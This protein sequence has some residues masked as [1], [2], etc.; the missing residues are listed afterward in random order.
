MFNFAEIWEWRAEGTNPARRVKRNPEKPRERHLLPEEIAKLGRILDERLA[1]GLETPFIV[2]VFKL[3]LLT[4]CRHSEIQT[5]KWSYL[6]NGAI[7]L[8]ETKTGPRRIPL[9]SAAKAILARLPRITDNPFVIA[10]DVP[11]QYATDLQRPWRRIREAAGLND[12]RIHDLRHTYASNA[13]KNGES[14]PTVGKLLGQ[15]QMQTTMRYAHWEDETLCAAAE[16]VSDAINAALAAPVI[17]NPFEMKSVSVGRV[18]I[19]EPA[20]DTDANDDAPSN[21]R[22]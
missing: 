14:L 19:L 18:D 20:N 2:A 4:G 10:G 9:P 13:V 11:G 1:A 12:V 5:L 16:N 6:K 22:S 8:P 3:L 7:E 15:S 21:F 17:E